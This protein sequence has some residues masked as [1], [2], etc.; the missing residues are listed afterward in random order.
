MTFAWV[1]ERRD[2]YPAATLCRVLGVSRSGFYAGAK[3]TRS[4]ASARR[5]ELLARAGLRRD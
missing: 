1:E 4:A 5:A 3:R 2:E